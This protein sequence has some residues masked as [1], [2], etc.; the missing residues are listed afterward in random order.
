MCVYVSLFL[1]SL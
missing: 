1:F